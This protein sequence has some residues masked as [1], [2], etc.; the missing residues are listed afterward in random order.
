[1]IPSY[2]NSPMLPLLEIKASKHWMVSW[3]KILQLRATV[4]FKCRL[5]IIAAVSLLSK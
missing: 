5:C 1:M 3:S 2:Y 4:E